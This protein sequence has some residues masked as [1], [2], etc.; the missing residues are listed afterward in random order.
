MAAYTE[1]MNRFERILFRIALVLAG[2]IVVIRLG[3]V[4]T[5]WY[6]HHVR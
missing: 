1:P 3:F 2:V 5:V 6:L 4:L